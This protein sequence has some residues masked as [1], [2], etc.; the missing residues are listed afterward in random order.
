MVE[1]F[2]EQVKHVRLERELTL[3]KLGQLMGCEGQRIG[4]VERGS[5]PSPTLRKKLEDW[6][7]NGSVPGLP[8]V[9]QTDSHAVEWARAIVR[10][11]ENVMAEDWRVRFEAIKQSGDP[12]A[13]RSKRA[14]H[15][16]PEPSADII[17]GNGIVELLRRSHR[18]TRRTAGKALSTVWPAPPWPSGACCMRR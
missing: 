1:K 10:R 4:Q 5:N 17:T 16:A 6:I 13:G 12:A 8:Q 11:A 18:S 9:G 2:A 15:S 14:Q 7:E 3:V